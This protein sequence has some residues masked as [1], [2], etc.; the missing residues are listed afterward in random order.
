MNSVGT[1]IIYLLPV[2]WLI[3]ACS[4]SNTNS[5][6]TYVADSGSEMEGIQS[7]TG[8]AVGSASNSSGG[9]DN[10]VT[11]TEGGAF[12]DDFE[13]CLSISE[14][15]E[16]TRGPA[17]LIIAIDNT[18]S[19]YNEIEEVRANMN[20]LSEIVSEQGLDLDIVLISCFSDDCLK[21]S[22]WH[23]ICIDPPVG[24][25][26]V[27]D[28]D[29]NSDDSNPP[30][31]LHINESIESRKALENIVN[32]YN[33]WR[34]MIR[35]NAVKHVLVVSDD[36]DDWTSED[37]HTR[38]T[39]LDSR[40]ADFRFHGIYSF[41]SKED[42]CAVSR[43]DPCCT[44]AAPDGEGAVYRQLVQM[45]G[46]VSGNMCLQD[47][48][49][50]F[51]ELAGAVIASAKLNCQW[52]I[53]EPPEGQSLEPDFV[54]VE[55]TDGDGNIFSFGRIASSEDCSRV[56]H[57]WYYDQPNS[58]S[59][60]HVCPQTCNWIQGQIAAKMEVKFGCETIWEIII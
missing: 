60:I 8:S 2:V 35:D 39:A 46:G 21:Q 31:F 16:N 24:A 59:T 37:F 55:Y 27:C 4:D 28:A 9:S 15:A 13:E 25:P 49:P 56:E 6:G 5:S 18:P 54:N 44:Y 51:D 58:P 19:M 10:T 53:P 43:D 47:F 45:T 26:D 36:G 32:T 1:Q 38:F 34:H 40:F 33:E 41:L 29:G 12:T 14:T 3:T 7:T 11:R 52:A 20:R 48:D 50:V 30:H 22:H 23:T 57:A 17:D 42:A